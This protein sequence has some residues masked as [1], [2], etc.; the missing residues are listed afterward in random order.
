MIRWSIRWLLLLLLL[1]LQMSL[2]LLLFLLLL[3]SVVV[4]AAVYCC[5]CCCCFCCCCCLLLLLLLLLLLFLLLFLLHWLI[6]SQWKMNFFFK[7]WPRLGCRHPV[8][9][10][11]F[12]IL[13]FGGLNMITLQ[14]GPFWVD[15]EKFFSHF[16]SCLGMPGHAHAYIEP[17]ICTKA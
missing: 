5:C 16:F 15:E 9:G 3:L 13:E 17:F 8:K 1:L 4:A 6:F 2:L 14:I 7:K 11:I 12:K 10:K